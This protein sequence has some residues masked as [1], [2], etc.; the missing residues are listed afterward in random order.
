MTFSE[1][2]CISGMTFLE[3]SRV[4]ALKH[5]KISENPR[6]LPGSMNLNS[7]VDELKLEKPYSGEPKYFGGFLEELEILMGNSQ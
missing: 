4:D 7:R 2:L 1:N 3:A 6:K 5:L